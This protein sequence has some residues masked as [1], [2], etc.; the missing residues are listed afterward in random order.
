MQRQL[1]DFRRLISF[2]F[3]HFK[4]NTYSG[5]RL[6]VLSVSMPTFGNATATE[7][8]FENTDVR[9]I[10]SLHRPFNTVSTKQ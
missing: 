5:N 9:R 6:Q 8:H 1:Y 7:K 2:F 3:V 10:A 4:M